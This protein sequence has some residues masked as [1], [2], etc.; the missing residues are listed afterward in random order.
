MQ[1][2]ITGTR[3][4]QRCWERKADE[5]SKSHSKEDLEQ[6]EREKCEEFYPT[7]ECMGTV[8]GRCGGAGSGWNNNKKNER[9]CA[10]KEAVSGQSH[11]RRTHWDCTFVFIPRRREG[12]REEG[13]RWSEIRCFLLITSSCDNHFQ[14]QT[15]GFSAA[16]PEVDGPCA[17][18]P[19]SRSSTSD[20]PP[21][22]PPLQQSFLGKPSQETVR[23]KCYLL[24]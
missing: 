13:S 21:F 3:S 24:N 6:R 16:R 8:G 14:K 19:A 15:G 1:S 4:E 9:K 23:P 20:F 7:F 2:L 10:V 11:V 5:K 22:V 17:L 18:T 12:E